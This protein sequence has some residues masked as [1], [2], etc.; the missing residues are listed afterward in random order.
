MA[1]ESFVDLIFT[2]QKT[3]VGLT[4]VRLG[5]YLYVKDPISCAIIGRPI[6]IDDNVNI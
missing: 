5:P 4:L 6:N 2:L 3:S 1:V